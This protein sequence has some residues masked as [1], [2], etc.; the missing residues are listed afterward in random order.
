MAKKKHTLLKAIGVTVAGTAAT[1][2]IANQII[3]KKEKNNIYGYGT[4]IET[5]FGKMNVS[6]CGNGSDTIVLLPGYGTDSPILDFE[7]LAKALSSFAKV[8]TIEYLGYGDSDDSERER[9]IENICEEVHA[10]L[11]SLNIKKYW[12]MPHSISG[13]YCLAYANYY[14]EEVEGMLLIDTSVP[15]QKDKADPKF[16]TILS[17]IMYY[18]GIGRIVMHLNPSMFV[19]SEDVYDKDSLAQMKLRVLQKASVAIEN[20][21]KLLGENM[22]KC[23]NML[24]PDKL[25]VLLFICKSTIDK[26]KDWWLDFHEEQLDNLETCALIPLDGTHYLHWTNAERMA[27]EVENFIS[28]NAESIIF[29]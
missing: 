15:K 1:L 9:T 25:P 24:W 4:K 23:R 22:D 10:V 26:R 17:K 18:T 13:I 12:M 14:P 29:E 11:E 28:F 6:I 20:E 19:G 3:T 7:P 5:P 16:E 21:G 27:E 8:V 2:A